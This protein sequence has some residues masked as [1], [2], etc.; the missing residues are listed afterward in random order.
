M[1]PSLGVLSSSSTLDS[2][3]T[4]S[5]HDVLCSGDTW[6]RPNSNSDGAPCCVRYATELPIHPNS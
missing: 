3:C 5:V 4:P 2:C 6:L 1:P